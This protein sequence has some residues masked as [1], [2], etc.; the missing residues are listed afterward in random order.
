MVYKT[1]EFTVCVDCLSWLANGDATSLDHYYRPDTAAARLESIQYGERR[2][3][4]Q[5]G[6]VHV[7]D[8]ENESEEWSNRAC[9]C[10]ML[11]DHG[12]RYPI[13]T[14]TGAH[15]RTSNDPFGRYPAVKYAA[16]QFI[17]SASVEE[18]A[19]H[20]NPRL[21]YTASGYGARIPT[22][23]MVRCADN[24][25]RRVYNRIYSNIGTLFIE[26]KG[27]QLILDVDS[28]QKLENAR[29]DTQ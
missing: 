12:A 3:T 28:Q 22:R 10:C 21:T 27:E 13:A 7:G 16:D 20:K 1:G 19:W 11:A 4:E 23:Y 26:Y 6:R 8:S 18:M 17:V 5:Y 24:R 2:L 29:E 9:D 25:K 15:G 14:Y